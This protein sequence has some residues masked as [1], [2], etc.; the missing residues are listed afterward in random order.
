MKP[1]VVLLMG[2]LAIAVAGGGAAAAEPAAGPNGP[3]PWT[4]DSPLPW[5]DDETTTENDS[6][7]APGQQ[8]AGAVGA[9]GAT[10]EGELWDRSLSERL[11]NATSDAER[12]AVLA[13]EIETI[14]TYVEALEGVRANLTESW[15]RGEL[16]EGEYRASLSGFVVRA[17][18]VELRANRTVNASEELSPVI[19]DAHDV[20]VT[21]ARNLSDRARDLY[22]FEGEIGREVVNETL[23]NESDSSGIPL[24]GESGEE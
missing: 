24:A 23:E 8:L 15:E 1:A 7:V 4:D 21:R 10:V 5:Q 18:S 2:V 22:Q 12:A 20:N 11:D 16:S 9:Q 17:R 19:R 3:P 13:D 14:E 6:S